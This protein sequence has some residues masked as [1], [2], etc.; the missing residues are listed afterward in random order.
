MGQEP[1]SSSTSSSPSPGSDNG[2]AP[3]QPHVDGT[4]GSGGGGA[5]AAAAGLPGAGTGAARI[6]PPVQSGA[7]E[8]PSTFEDWI[9]EDRFYDAILMHAKSCV[10]PLGWNDWQGVALLVKEGYDEAVGAA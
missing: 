5:T 1:P 9:S 8:E 7:G 3:Q 6:I 2:P 10:V 4:D